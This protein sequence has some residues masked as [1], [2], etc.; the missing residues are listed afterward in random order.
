M[1]RKSLF[2]LFILLLAACG[3]KEKEP[4]TAF[5]K[6]EIIPTIYYTLAIDYVTDKNFSNS[7]KLEVIEKG[8]TIQVTATVENTGKTDYKFGGNPCS[9]HLGVSFRN[10]DTV[11]P[12]TGDV[13]PDF[14]IESYAEHVLKTGEKLTASAKFDL[15]GI[16]PGVY[17]LS[18][19]YANRQ[20]VKKIKVID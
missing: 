15:K 5:Y 3:Q 6:K 1:G 2:L 10:K 14:C 8:Q 11:V 4:Q 7:P 20:F 17:E 12:G 18:S 16:E 9:G 13:A 19:S